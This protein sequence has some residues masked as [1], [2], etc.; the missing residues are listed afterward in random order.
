MSSAAILVFLFFTFTFTYLLFK[1]FLQPKPKIKRPPG[2]SPLPII[3]NLHHILCAL[4]H[5]KLH[6]LSQKYG[7]IMCLQLGQVPTVIIASS[8]AAE[9]FLKTH[10]LVFASRPKIQASEIF[11]Y[12]S[13]GL[14][15][16]AYGPYW[17]SV[18]K[19]CT[20]KLL[21]A[22]KV[23]MFAPV[24]KEELGVLV[25]SLK[26]DALVGKVVNVSEILENLVE[27]IVYKMVLGR[28]HYEQFDVKELIQQGMAL[29][30]A[31][32]LA[33]FVPWLGVFDLQGLTRKC[34]KIS[35]AMD[36]VLEMIITEHE[37]NPIVD[38]NTNEDFVDIL[39]STIHEDI[40]HEAEENRVSDRT[41]IKAILLDMIVAA[42]DTSATSSQWAMSELL[43][44]PRVMKKLQ[45]QIQNE[46]GN[47]RMVEEKD[48]K[49][50][51]YL[52][53]VIDEMLRVHPVAPLLVPRES[54]ESITIDG[55]FIEKKTRV[56]V[57]AWSI[58]RDPT[59]WSNPEEFYPERFVDKKLNYQG[60]EFESIPFG[61]GR[62][63]CAGMNMG[64]TTVKLIISQLVH[65]FDWE[66]PKNV[67]PSNLNMEEKFGLTVTRAQPLRAIPRYRLGD[68]KHEQA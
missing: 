8:K 52:D 45:N 24:R 14:A 15:F 41:Y 47:D 10:D 50:F 3:G 31:F 63:G 64:L 67:T 57:N 19:L 13:R 5:R 33:D 29:L 7:P 55:Y 44:H 65:C 40:D 46:V 22:S 59:N 66:L 21:S 30:G 39:L 68:A 25:E 34:K 4:P 37:Q 28:C 17:R 51:T 26:K 58:S 18:R 62:R 20:L 2:P 35:K 12:G 6:T 60:Q 53:M 36:E 23:E 1:L 43:R 11:S 38:Q 27:N 16:S 56:M 49:K 61:S 48:V 32:N 54:R 42:S 9:S